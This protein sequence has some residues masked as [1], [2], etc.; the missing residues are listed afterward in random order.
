MSPEMVLVMKPDGTGQALYDEKIDL[1]V[2]G[3]LH[4]ERAT[5]IEFDDRTQCW[6]VDDPNGKRLFQHA[7]R[8]VCLNWER[9]HFSG[10]HR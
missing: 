10:G 9:K 6:R 1:N 7:S 3:P 4:I 5:I 2:L 8:Q